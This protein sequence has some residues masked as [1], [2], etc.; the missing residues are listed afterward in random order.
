MLQSARPSAQLPTP[1]TPITHA[2]IPLVGVGHVRPHIPQCAT[3][4]LRFTSQPFAA[5]MSQS[6]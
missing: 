4:A 6:A 3:L 1:H 5:L 2:G